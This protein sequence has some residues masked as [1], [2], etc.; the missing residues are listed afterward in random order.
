MKK[1]HPRKIICK[2]CDETFKE[3]CDLEEHINLHHG[4]TEKFDCKDCGKTF[5][6]KWRLQK[7]EENHINSNIKKCHYFNNNKDCPYE[8]IGCMFAHS[9]SEMC[10]HGK[11]CKN[12]LCSYQHTPEIII[13]DGLHTEDESDNIFIDEKV[14]KSHCDCT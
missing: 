5:V 8:K 4:S 9:P 6:L 12:L 3:N 11:S 10:I 2:L 1:V 7:H 14:D 13:D